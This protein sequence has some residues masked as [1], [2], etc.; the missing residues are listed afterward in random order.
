M[1][2]VATK[3]TDSPRPHTLSSALLRPVS[4]AIGLFECH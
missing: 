4:L 2:S 1:R 3:G